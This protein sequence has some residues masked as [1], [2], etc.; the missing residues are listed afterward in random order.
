MRELFDEGRWDELEKRL[1]TALEED[2]RDARS[3]F[4]LG[5][6]LILAARRGENRLGEIRG[7][8]DVGLSQ[9]WRAA[10]C[11][12]NQGV[13]LAQANKGRPALDAFRRALKENRL[14]GPAAYNLG[15]LLERLSDD[16]L[17]R[18]V[19]LDLNL[20]V[21]GTSP[22]EL[23]QRTFK[24]AVDADGWEEGNSPLDAPLYLWGEDLPSGFGF[25]PN[26][27]EENLK[28]GNRYLSEGIAHLE[29]GK[30][31]QAIHSFA[32]A[33]TY[34]KDLEAEIVPYRMQAQIA[35]ARE[36]RQ[37]LGTSR[38]R[39]GSTMH[40]RPSRPIMV[41]PPACPIERW[42]RSCCCRRST[43]SASNSGTMSLPPTGA[44]S[45]R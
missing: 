14:C 25:E 33:T 29:S 11:L 4:Q 19:L 17:L 34:N 12:N 35:L 5:N 13:A 30:Y 1:K 31:Q 27:A 18:R 44:S 38:L 45:K 39:G 23:I 40:A 16:G 43:P 2:P 26:V 8:Y 9:R 41:W 42:P 3:A 10:I 21:D 6:L 20:A 22:K 15:I 36:F 28:E 24:E 32:S 7:Y 37:R